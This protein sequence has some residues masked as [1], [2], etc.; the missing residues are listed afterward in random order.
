MNKIQQQIGISLVLSSKVLMVG[1]DYHDHR[2]GVGAVIEVY[3]RNFEVF[4]FISTYKGG[5]FFIKDMFLL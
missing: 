5:S 2:G 3:S 1:P 4:N